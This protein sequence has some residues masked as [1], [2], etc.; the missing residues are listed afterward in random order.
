[1]HFYSS[2]TVSRILPCHPRQ[3]NP[4]ARSLLSYKLAAEPT[5][6]CHEQNKIGC[7]EGNEIDMNDADINQ[8]LERL[9]PDSFGWALQCCARHHE[10]AQD[11]LQSVYQ[12]VLEGRARFDGRATFK[13]WLFAVIRRTAA[14]ERRRA[15]V[16]RLWLGRF[17]REPRSEAAVADA[18]RRLDR[19]E[20][21]QV[22]Q[23]ALAR[24]PARQRQTLEL[25]FYHDLTIEQAAEVMGVS[26]GSA[27]THYDRGKKRL[28][29]LLEQ[30]EESHETVTRRDRDHAASAVL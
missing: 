6:G 28:R 25:V 14:E 18:G 24:L 7:A 30:S 9:H 8:E 27:R 5:N 1:M 16:R 17:D 26:V 21:Q 4:F 19:V 23:E 15:M 10:E 3:M 20:Q 12:K 22:F 13:T 11:V 2:F 29:H